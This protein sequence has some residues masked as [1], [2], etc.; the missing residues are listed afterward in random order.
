MTNEIYV[1]YG[2]KRARSIHY[3]SL[4]FV[5]LLKVRIKYIQKRY[6]YLYKKHA[7]V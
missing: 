7:L 4:I 3:T 5:A 1:M 2:L 6:K